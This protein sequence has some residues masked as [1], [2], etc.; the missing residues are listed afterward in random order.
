M[1]AV[2]AGPDDAMA[3]GIEVGYMEG[4]QLAGEEFTPLACAFIAYIHA[5]L[6][7]FFNPQKNARNHGSLDF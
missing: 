3:K 2:E 1:R 7:L 6:D 4:F 5:A